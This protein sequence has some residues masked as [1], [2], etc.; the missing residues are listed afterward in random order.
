MTDLTP[1]F[2]PRAVIDGRT[3]G[4]APVGFIVGIVIT[5]ACGIVALGLDMA[6]SFSAG[7]GAVPFFVALPLALLPVPLLVGVVL[8]VDRLE[9]EPRANLVFA[10]GWGAG[11]AAL[12]ALLINTAGLVYVTQPDLGSTAGEFVSATFGAPFVEETLKGAVL[13]GLLWRRRQE[14]DGP[15]D[16]I[17]YAAMVGL[18][19]AMIENVGYYINAMITPTHGGV[20]LLGFTFVLRGVLS[21]L[22]H[23]MFTSMTGLGVAYAAGRRHVGPWPVLAGWLG[24][25]LLHGTWN[26]LSAWGAP[27]LAIAYVIM[28]LVGLAIL[29]ILVQ[30]RRRLVRLIRRYLPPYEPT[31]LLS[32]G[33]IAMLAS[34]RARRRARNWARAS[35]GLPAA[36]A[37]SDYQLA[38]TELALLHSKAEQGLVAAPAFLDRQHDLVGLMHVARAAFQARHDGRPPAPWSASGQSGFA[39]GVTRA[40]RLPPHSPPR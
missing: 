8:W 20:A 36:E 26:G 17:I 40:T 28:S 19:F 24:A 18:G 14:F 30:D 32:D 7:D 11:I 12:L 9:P 38:A 25:M 2:D 22:L 29:V 4:R 6:Q 39:H 13:V 15:T 33:D 23:P 21:P 5:A 31:G 37:M 10:F 35:A 27:G 3:P 16:G 1:V 34:L